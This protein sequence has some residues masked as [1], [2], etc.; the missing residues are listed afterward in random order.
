MNKALLTLLLAILLALWPVTPLLASEE[1]S[2]GSIGSGTGIENVAPVIEEGSLI[3]RI[4]D[5]EGTAWGWSAGGPNTGDRAIPYILNG[6]QLHFE[7]EVTD[8]NGEADLTAMLV[9]MNLGP[10]ISFNGNFVSTTIDQDNGISKGSYSGDLTADDNM[11]T[12][13]YDITIDV[14]DPA[15][16]TDAYDPAIYEPNADILRPA[17][18]LE[19]SSPAVLFPQSNPGDLGIAANDSP[20]R[21]TP[22]AVI[23]TEHIPVVF[24]ISHSGTDMVNGGNVLPVGSIVW[25]TTS[26]VTGNGLSSASQIIA[27]AVQE[28]TTVEV[29]YW[30]NVPFPQAAGSYNGTI[31]FYYI[32]D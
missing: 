5:N 19:V 1:G 11:A 31:D 14:T 20:V 26:Q 15:G 17:V 13:K 3:V 18:S 30:L 29:Y 25:S 8:A 10:D 21:L 24:S 2:G 28:D 23:G 12:G 7:L 6:E 4:I 27:S 16:A 22:Q 32:A 9:K